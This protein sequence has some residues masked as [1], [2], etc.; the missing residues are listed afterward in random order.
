MLYLT[1]KMHNWRYFKATIA[2]FV[3]WRVGD[4]EREITATRRGYGQNTGCN[5]KRDSRRFDRDSVGIWGKRLGA[6][7]ETAGSNGG[8]GEKAINSE[9]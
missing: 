4:W 8:T 1:D 5:A 6:I 2:D 3:F 7:S 9:D